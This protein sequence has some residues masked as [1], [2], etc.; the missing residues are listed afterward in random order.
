MVLYRCYSWKDYHGEEETI[1]EEMF[2]CILDLWWKTPKMSTLQEEIL[3]QWQ[4]A[5][6]WSLGEVQ[7][8][9]TPFGHTAELPSPVLMQLT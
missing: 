8:G 3:S 4:S 7:P 5:L 6:K 2:T 9:S 1:K